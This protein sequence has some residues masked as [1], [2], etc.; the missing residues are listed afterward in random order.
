MK[1]KKV[2]QKAL[3]KIHEGWCQRNWAADKNGET[4]T[5]KAKNAVAWDMQGAIMAALP[6]VDSENR[7]LSPEIQA[8]EFM[9]RRVIS[10]I[11]HRNHTRISLMTWNDWPNRGK[12]QVVA[13]FETAIS[14]CGAL[15]P[16][17]PR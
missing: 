2:L 6:K 4:T 12:S 7:T 8:A 10:R 1:T 14:R 17:R 16:T 11:R 5:P 15:R 9:L 13:V 3:K